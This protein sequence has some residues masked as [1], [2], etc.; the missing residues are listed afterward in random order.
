MREFSANCL[1]PTLV[2]FNPG[3]GY[4]G[5]WEVRCVSALVAH[6]P[7]GGSVAYHAHW[8]MSIRGSMVA[9]CRRQMKL[10]DMSMLIVAFGVL[11]FDSMG[12]LV[13]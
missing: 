11:S 3:V 12:Y 4:R 9:G 8:P 13:D 7:L 6:L 1:S 2:W 5:N 10:S